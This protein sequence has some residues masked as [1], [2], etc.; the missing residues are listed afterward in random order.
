M[1][2]IKFLSITTKHK[3]VDSSHCREALYMLV[4]ALP[5]GCQNPVDSDASLPDYYHLSFG[6]V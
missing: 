1:H 3:L 5:R 4:C 2:L 6:L